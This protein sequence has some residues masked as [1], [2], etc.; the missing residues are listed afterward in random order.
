M[1]ESS[2]IP[3]TP[4]SAEATVDAE[5]ADGTAMKR[6]RDAC[7]D[8][9]EVAVSVEEPKQERRG[10]KHARLGVHATSSVQQPSQAKK[11]KNGHYNKRRSARNPAT[12][13]VASPVVKS[14]DVILCSPTV[15]SSDAA[16]SPRDSSVMSPASVSAASRVFSTLPPELAGEFSA[17]HAMYFHGIA[18][19]SSNSPV[20]S[21]VPPPMSVDSFASTTPLFEH[22]HR[23]VAIDP[24][25]LLVEPHSP[26]DLF[27]QDDGFTPSISSGQDS[28]VEDPEESK[29]ATPAALFGVTLEPIVNDQ[30]FC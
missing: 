7:D 26:E 8:D 11:K 12:E 21:M 1:N 15:F 27:Q 9:D 10:R 24:A 30:C 4:E 14:E 16:S 19:P 25:L 20:L 13:V 23:V 2:S 29:T 5:N 22:T 6:P 18:C 17:E 3:Q 28:E